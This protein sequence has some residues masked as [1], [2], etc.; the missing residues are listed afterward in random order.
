M[1]PSEPQMRRLVFF[2]IREKP[3][4]KVK[5]SKSSLL[6]GVNQC[7][8]KKQRSKMKVILKEEV[9]L[10][11]SREVLLSLSKRHTL[12]TMSY[13]SLTKKKEQTNKIKAREKK[14]RSKR[15]VISRAGI[16]DRFTARWL[17]RS[18]ANN[19]ES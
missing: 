17:D 2:C 4:K 6:R 11:D 8:G 19:E 16:D 18:S 14:A 3:G 5:K 9:L 1:K 10:R 15:C 12:W 7:L 13:I